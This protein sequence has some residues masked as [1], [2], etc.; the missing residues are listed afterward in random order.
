MP[1]IE[2]RVLFMSVVEKTRV[3]FISVFETR[4]PFMPLVENI[5]LLS[6]W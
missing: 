6:L 5:V 4:V 1:V 3:L 2:N